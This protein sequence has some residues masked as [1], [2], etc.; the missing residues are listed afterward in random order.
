MFL[1]SKIENSRASTEVP[2]V[3]QFI[4]RYKKKT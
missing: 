3:V 4:R 2:D 1:I